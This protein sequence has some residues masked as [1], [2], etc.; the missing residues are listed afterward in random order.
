MGPLVWVMV[1]L[2]IWHFTVYLPDHFAGGIAGAFLGAV[3]GSVL[4]GLVL[5]G[6]GV[7]SRD[8]VDLMT[9]FEGIPGTIVGMAVVYVEGLRREKLDA[10]QD[11]TLTRTA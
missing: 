5:H 4:G 1:G 6:F 10:E 3:V 11:H 9:F 8:D 7:P 2:A